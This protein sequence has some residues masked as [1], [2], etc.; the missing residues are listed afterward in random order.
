VEIDKFFRFV[1]YICALKEKIAGVIRANIY[2]FIC[3]LLLTLGTFIFVKDL[4]LGRN[5]EET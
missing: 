5:E 2:F 1:V 3:H 4:L